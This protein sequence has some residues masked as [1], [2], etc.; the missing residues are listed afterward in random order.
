MKSRKFQM[1]QAKEALKNSKD[2]SADETNLV[3]I[4]NEIIQ[5]DDYF[6]AMVAYNNLLEISV[7]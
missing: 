6:D 4:K 5:H 1:L 2:F 3:Y 7:K